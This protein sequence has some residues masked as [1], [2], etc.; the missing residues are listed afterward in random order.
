VKICGLTRE[1][2]AELCIEAGA[3]AI[4]LNFVP[5]SRRRVDEAVARRIVDRVRGRIV[6]VA[7]VADLG[8]RELERLA[9]ATG[10][11]RLQLHGHE[12]PEA[13]GA[14]GPNAFKAARIGDASDALAAAA[15]PGEWLLVDAKAPGGELGGTGARFDWSLV[16]SLVRSRKVIV[17]GGLDPSNVA[18]AVRELE[19]FGVDVASGV[20]SSPGIKDPAKVRAFIAAARG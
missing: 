2:D 5:T 1:E 9:R 6:T 8:V 14:A 15:F 7:V 10:V 18:G 11:E 4:G 19:P 16:K 13:V 20:E 17:A 12:S 3:T